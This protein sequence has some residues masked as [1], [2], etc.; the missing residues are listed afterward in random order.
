[1]VHKDSGTRLVPAE[2]LL[3]VRDVAMRLGVCTATVYALIQQGKLAHI[4]ILNSIRIRPA[5]LSLYVGK[6]RR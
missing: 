3:N 4:R 1:M 6:E 5:D 2:R